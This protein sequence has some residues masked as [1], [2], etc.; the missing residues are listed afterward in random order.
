MSATAEVGYTVIH[1]YVLDRRHV[2]GIPRPDE[3]EIEIEADAVDLTEYDAV[4]LTEYDA[5]STRSVTV[6]GRLVH[7]GNSVHRRR[8]TWFLRNPDMPENVR[9]LVKILR[10]EWVAG[11]GDQE[12]TTPRPQAESLPPHL[13]VARSGRGL[14]KLPDIPG[15]YGGHAEVYESSAASEPHLWLKVVETG[16]SRLDRQDADATLHL[17]AEQAWQLAEQLMQSV[18]GHYHGDARPAARFADILDTPD[19]G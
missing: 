8:L 12:M 13:T 11:R 16:S 15:A 5:S 17:N 18:R 14:V 9:E 3:P 4:D 10:P 7:A 19:R 6:L 2:R 1:G